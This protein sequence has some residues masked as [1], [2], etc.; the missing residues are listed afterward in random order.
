MRTNLRPVTGNED[1]IR[2][3]REMLY[4][5]A[6]WGPGE[7][8]PIEEVLSDPA[9]SRYIEGWGRA[10]DD[11]LIAEDGMRVGATWHRLFTDGE[12]GYGFNSPTIPEITIGV[13]ASAR[14]RGIGTSLLAALIERARDEGHP[15]L[16]LSVERE[17]RAARFYERL[18]FVR[19]GEVANAWTMRLELS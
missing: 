2:F 6:T 4:E 19:V 14:G 5:A 15:A 8:P 13:C 11:A 1:D 18:G 12:P 9:I 3:L 17:N 7:R 16:S 10:D